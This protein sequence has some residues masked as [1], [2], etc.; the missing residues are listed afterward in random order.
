MQALRKNQSTHQAVESALKRSL[1]NW[2]TKQVSDTTHQ[3]IELI[4]VEQ[5][6][7][8]IFEG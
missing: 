5:K 6:E 4:E 7:N 3:I 1:N 8:L 2:E